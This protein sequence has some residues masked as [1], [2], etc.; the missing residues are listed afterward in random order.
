VSITVTPAPVGCT[1][2]APAVDTK[3]SAEFKK[4]S[5]TFK[6]PALSTSGPNE[7]LVAFI[8]ADG[9]Q[10]TSQ[11][12][13]SVSGGG[14]KWTRAA[15]ENRGWGTT[16]VWYAYASA[17]ASN[18]SVTAKLASAYDGAITV[19]AFTG[20]S[21]KIGATGTG[22][23]TKGT[24]AATVTTKACN[25]LVWAAGHDWTNSSAVSA[26]AGQTLVH[27]FVD[28]R[29]KDTFWTQ[30]VDTATVKAGDKVGV[31]T[32]GPTKDRWTMAAVEILPAG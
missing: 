32:N 7:L 21:S 14:L 29:V 6:A 18:V 4:A 27:T 2:A 17:K 28:T 11:K 12:V 16:E 9:P 31:S 30:K 26:P 24:P 19:V 10:N 13:T 20:A 5:S 22:W 23:G 25:S 15:A 8:G 1:A 3:V